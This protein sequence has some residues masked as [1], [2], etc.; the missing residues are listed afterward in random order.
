M[1]DPSII[2]N[3]T[4]AAQAQQEANMKALGDLGGAFGK[5]L[6]ARQINDM[7]QMA[8]PEEEKAFAQKHKLFAP[9]L[10]QQYNDNRAA[11]VKSLRDGLKFY[12]DLGKTD[13][14]TG[15]LKSESGKIDAEKGKIS[16]ET[17]G[18]DIDQDSKL[19]SMVWG[20]VL[21]GGKNAGLARL[22]M[23]KSRGLIDEATYN[24]QV[25]FINNL[26]SDLKLAQEYAM[27]MYRGIQDPKYILPTA[28]NTQD[29]QTLTN[30]NIR[31]NQ[32]R[33][34]VAN[35]NGEWGV[36]QAATT[37]EYGLQR[38]TISQTHQDGR[39]QLQNKIE[40]QKLRM[41]QEQ[42]QLVT[43][44]DG[45]AYVFYPNR[46]K[47]KF[48]P[49]YGK[50]GNQ[51][52][53]EAG[54]MG[55]VSNKPM[56][57]SAL[58][59][60]STSRDKIQSSQNTIDK[61]EQSIKD[62]DPKQ[63]GKLS[64]GLLGNA[65]NVARNLTGNSNESSLAYERLNSNIKG[66]VNEVLQM[67][68]GTQTE[69]DAQRAAKVILSTPL[70][71]NR[72]VSNA[73]AELKRVAQKTVALEQGKVE[74]VYSNYGKEAPMYPAASAPPAGIAAPKTPSGKP[75]PPLSAYGF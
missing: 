71:D 7:N 19:N 39:S 2:T 27:A 32:G 42:S 49:Y 24:Q 52:V 73:L 36:K 59:L 47:N 11:E 48:E 65:G 69:G 51:M 67:A 56:P 13:A 38:E 63:G 14:E 64:L 57:A 3:G 37:G 66:M 18:M 53:G 16:V 34:Q 43:G 72:A 6:L 26:P 61:I 46:P 45:K 35:I 74:E 5:L 55:A 44:T 28:D 9:Q 4:L 22:E 20:S 41:Q 21:S 1:L 29:N 54:K 8:T 30:N 12:S 70:T 25:G 50:D 68:K 33:V 58:N 40:Q 10:M 75:R 23:Q 62:L 17:K 60:V 15:K 31:D